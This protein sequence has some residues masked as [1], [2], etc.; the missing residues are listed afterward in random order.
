MRRYTLRN[1][2]DCTPEQ[3]TDVLTIRNSDAVR[4]AMYTEHIIGSDEHQG[5]LL[6]LSGDERQQVFV[7]L[8]EGRTVVGTVS[9]SQIDLLHKKADWAFYLDTSARGGVGAAL[10]VFMLDYVFGPL[11]LEKLNC[12]VLETNPRVVEMH[13]RFGFTEEGFRAANI[14]KD[15]KRIGV[16]LLGMQKM[17]WQTRRTQVL[18]N[19]AP[20]IG[21]IEIKF[22]VKIIV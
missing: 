11:G 20:K 17:E 22:D 19:L 4:R 3:Q 6:G 21:D 5:W 16:H 18:E 7:V 10:E 1:I 14:E 9:V 13:K 12:E 2:G 8:S 15:G